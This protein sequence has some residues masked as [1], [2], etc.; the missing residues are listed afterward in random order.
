MI[1][2]L[3]TSVTTRIKAKKAALGGFL[4]STSAAL[5]GFRALLISVVKTGCIL[6][7]FAPYMGLFNILQHWRGELIP[8]ANDRRSLV[9]ATPGLF[10]E[11]PGYEYYIGTLRD[12][13]LLFLALL[14]VQIFLI[15]CVQVT[16]SNQFRNCSKWSMLQ[17][18][19][20]S[21]S[22]ADSNQDWSAGPGSVSEHFQRRKRH[23]MEVLIV[24]ALQWLVNIIMCVPLWISGIY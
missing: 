5:I 7:F 13:Y 20:N 4:P 19:L 2:S 14:G 12:G 24:G 17:K 15:F 16:I 22:L 11:D 6:F 3:R 8:L 1:W 9:E 18:V 23:L 10:R 21:F